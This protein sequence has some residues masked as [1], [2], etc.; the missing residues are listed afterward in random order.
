[1]KKIAFTIS[2]A[3][4]AAF[5]KSLN[6]TIMIKFV[7]SEPYSNDDKDHTNVTVKYRYDSDLFYLGWRFAN[8]IQNR[9]I[10]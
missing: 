6:E 3:D 7:S 10:S 1:M 5:I 9:N 2:T 4:M 8:E